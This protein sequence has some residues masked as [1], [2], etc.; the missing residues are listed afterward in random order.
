MAKYECSKIKLL[1]DTVAGAIYPENAKHEDI[2]AS[3][4]IIIQ[5]LKLQEKKQLGV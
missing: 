4:E 3:L 1:P 5:Q 2:V